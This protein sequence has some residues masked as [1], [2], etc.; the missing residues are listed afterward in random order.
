MARKGK[1][2]DAEEAALGADVGDA[3]GAASLFEVEESPPPASDVAEAVE[4]G[5]G[6][7]RGGSG[8]ALPICRPSR[9]LPASVEE[10]EDEEEPEED[11]DDED[12]EMT[13]LLP[14]LFTASTEPDGESLD[15]AVEEG[16]RKT[17]AFV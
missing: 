1:N 12:E 8:S 4:E 11:D 7:G 13:L 14:P 16:D 17:T 2:E 5:S 15:V 10:E 6:G 9:R 3:E